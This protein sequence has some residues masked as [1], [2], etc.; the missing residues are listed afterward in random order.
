MFNSEGPERSFEKKNNSKTDCIPGDKR[1]QPIF[2]CF[3]ECDERQAKI[4]YAPERLL[5]TIV[6]VIRSFL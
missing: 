2:T 3:I 5:T 6:E 1:F 4:Y